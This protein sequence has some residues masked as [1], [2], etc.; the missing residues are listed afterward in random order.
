VL[1]GRSSGV[2]DAHA[3]ATGPT[4]RT[5][6]LLPPLRLGP[7][8]HG[9]LRERHPSWLRQCFKGAKRRAVR[10]ERSKGAAERHDKGRSP[11]APARLVREP[12][13]E[14]GGKS[15][16]DHG[17][18]TLTFW[19][20]NV[21]NVRLSVFKTLTD[22]SRY[23]LRST[24]GRASRRDCQARMRRGQVEVEEL[25]RPTRGTHSYDGTGAR[26]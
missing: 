9:H 18:P 21:V 8:R 13:R 22:A 7:P 10:R 20:L 16:P 25:R 2:E 23:V 15:R 6:Q 26:R 1:S 19:S 3:T 17:L 5:P 12:G 14:G 4:R 24:M 11:K